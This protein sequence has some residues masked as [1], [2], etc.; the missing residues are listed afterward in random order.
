LAISLQV[1]AESGGGERHCRGRSISIP[2]RERP[3]TFL[4]ARDERVTTLQQAERALKTAVDREAVFAAFYWFV[5]D[6]FAYSALFAVRGRFAVGVDADGEGAPG[7][8]VR[9]IQ[10]PFDP[11]RTHAVARELGRPRDAVALVVPVFVGARVVAFVYADGGVA[12]I[13]EE[14]SA[15]IRRVAQLAGHAF[16]RIIVQK[17]RGS[18]PPEG[19]RHEDARID[20]RIDV[21]GDPPVRRPRLLLVEES[22]PRLLLVDEAADASEPELPFELERR[23]EPRASLGVD[24]SL[25]S[26]STFFV[27]L[28]G[29]LS[30]GGVFVVTYQAVRKGSEVDLEFRLPRVTVHARGRVRWLRRATEDTPPGVGIAF[31]AMSAPDREHIESFCRKRQPLYYDL[32]D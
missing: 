19:P 16:E 12:E 32:D 21:G 31:T 1:A 20:A 26:E 23:A 29:D 30:E 8:L 15:Q 13:D 18:D 22:G 28:T 10:W 24:I 4:R 5:R 14:T 6:C 7:E 9:T 2:V 3:P 17:K 27:G 11:W 25:S